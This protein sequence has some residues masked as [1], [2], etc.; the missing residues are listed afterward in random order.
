MSF[1]L[2]HPTNQ[3]KTLPIRAALPPLFQNSGSSN[4][5]NQIV[6]ANNNTE[7]SENKDVG[8]NNKNNNNN[9]SD[10]FFDNI[11]MYLD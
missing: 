4:F 5:E 11:D 1:Y 8:E 3:S 10:L 6:D 9:K 7:D 2:H